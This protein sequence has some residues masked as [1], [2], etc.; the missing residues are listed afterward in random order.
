MALVLA[1]IFASVLTLGF[2]FLSLGRRPEQVR[3]ARLAG[4]AKQPE[5][6][7]ESGVLTRQELRWFDRVMQ[8]FARSQTKANEQAIATVRRRLNYAGFRS[9]SSLMTY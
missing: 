7:V 9:E 5:T 6:A 4:N 3:L 2:A 1:L 8:P